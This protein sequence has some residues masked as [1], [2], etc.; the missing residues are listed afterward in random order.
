MEHEILYCST[1]GFV[2][3]IAYGSI[4]TVRD[5][6]GLALSSVSLIISCNRS[7]L[8]QHEILQ[9]ILQVSSR[10]C[11]SLYVYSALVCAMREKVWSKLIVQRIIF[12]SGL[13]I[14]SK[15]GHM[16]LVSGW[17]GGVPPDRP[18]CVRSSLPMHS[19]FCLVYLRYRCSVD[20]YGMFSVTVFIALL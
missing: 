5:R 12:R 4:Q 11:K 3:V 8:K 6:V 7:L 10:E 2:A 13:L 16:G 19:L 17:D 9:L 15:V 20:C 18:C 14:E 1:I